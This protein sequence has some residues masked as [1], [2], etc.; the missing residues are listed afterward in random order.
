ML[1][2]T[3]GRKENAELPGMQ[4]RRYFKGDLFFKNGLETTMQNKDTK[5]LP[6]P[7][8]PVGGGR[9]SRHQLR[10]QNKRQ[11]CGEPRRTLFVLV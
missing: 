5:A 7:S 6:M 8:K 9:V 11:L 10:K 3:E 4:Q 2:I 1:K